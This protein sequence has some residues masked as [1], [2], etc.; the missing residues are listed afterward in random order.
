MAN[1]EDLKR[2]FS[3]IARA[4]GSTTGVI[5]EN[6]LRS[7]KSG[8]HDQ[9]HVKEGQ[10]VQGAGAGYAGGS[11]LPSL[12]GNTSNNYGTSANTRTSSQDRITDMFNS[13]REATLARL[14]ESYAQQHDTLAHEESKVAPAYHDARGQVHT[15]GQ[16]AARRLSELLR[17]QATGD[18][19]QAQLTQSVTTQQGMTDL[20]RQE[21]QTMDEFGRQRLGLQRQEQSDIN[22]SMAQLD[23]QKSQ[24][25]LQDFYHQMQMDMQ[26]QQLDLSRDTFQFKKD[27]AEVEDSRYMQEYKDTQEYR[28]WQ[29][30]MEERKMDMT[31]D[32]FN[33]QMELKRRDMQMKE[34]EYTARVNSYLQPSS[35]SELAVL[36]SLS[37]EQRAVYNDLIHNMA[38]QDDPINSKSYLIENLDDYISQIGGEAFEIIYNKVAEEADKYNV[39]KGGIDDYR[40]IIRDEF[41]SQDSIEGNVVNSQGIADRIKSWEDSGVDTRIVETLK[42]EYSMYLPQVTQPST[43]TTETTHVQPQV[44]EPATTSG[45]SQ[46]P[47]FNSYLQQVSKQQQ[48][49]GLNNS[50]FLQYLQT[51]EKALSSQ[52]GAEYVRQLIKHFSK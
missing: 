47:V 24:A 36:S 26:Q 19:A 52:I 2:Q 15:A 51:N 46:D 30:E 5:D 21:R 38:S 18:H 39:P 12:G 10:I 23:A 17:T 28:D 31:E 16:Q 34:A 11:S 14:R 22:A 8:T 32:Q 42:R 40:R 50:E 6:V 44:R 41:L 20:Q 25:L 48:E 43:P 3:D 27:R 1:Y 33:Q 29:R 9:W 45:A 13:Q 37:P 7:I 4:S 49:L 35:R